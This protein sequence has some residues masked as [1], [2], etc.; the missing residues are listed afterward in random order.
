MDCEEVLFNFKTDK[1]IPYN[2]KISDGNLTIN[3]NESKI[4]IRVYAQILTR[5]END[6]RIF[7][8][9]TNINLNEEMKV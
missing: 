1:Y 7:S 4:N 8:G 3:I 2:D 6:L 5:I 9:R